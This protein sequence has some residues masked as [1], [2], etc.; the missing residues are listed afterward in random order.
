MTDTGYKLRGINPQYSPL[1][2]PSVAFLLRG[3]AKR[4]LFPFSDRLPGGFSNFNFTHGFNQLAYNDGIA[5][6]GTPI[7]FIEE[8]TLC[9][10]R[11]ST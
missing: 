5:T 4:L 8:L 6:D 11:R 9:A 7:A 1:G 10:R 2:H 3:V